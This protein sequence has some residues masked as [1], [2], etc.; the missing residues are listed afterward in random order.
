[1][2]ILSFDVGIKN[3]AYCFIDTDCQTIMDWAVVDLCGDKRQCNTL[4]CNKNA[5]FM[6]NETY[7][8][9]KHIKE[10]LKE[11]PELRIPDAKINKEVIMDCPVGNLRKF[12]TLFDVENKK[13]PTDD[14]R[15]TMCEYI[16]DHLIE[17]VLNRNA[18][19][20]DLI[21]IGTNMDIYF[22]KLF[23]VINSSTSASFSKPDIVL[24]ENQISPIA[25]RM[26]T[27]QGMIAQFFITHF[28]GESIPIK[29]VSSSN[30]LKGFVDGKTTYDERKKKGIEVT[31]DLLNN[32]TSNKA[33]WLEV[34]QK[35]SKKDDLADSYLQALWYSRT[36]LKL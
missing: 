24:I 20:V 29:F 21:E 17:H 1:M 4:S 6:K 10:F 14:L 11:N 3:L 5:P 33:K 22:N 23:D 7:Y 36:I 19:N 32:H 18:K 12:A 26:K 16:D 25:N 15:E 31:I 35:H 34:F 8:C 27:I 2:K 13:I 30:K 28:R 9:N